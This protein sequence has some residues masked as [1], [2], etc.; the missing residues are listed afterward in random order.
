MQVL[1]RKDIF[2][3]MDSK[4]YAKL[5]SKIAPNSEV[6]YKNILYCVWKNRFIDK[7]QT[8]SSKLGD[9]LFF[10][11][12]WEKKFPKNEIKLEK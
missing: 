11:E 10:K 8:K 7:M 1:E 3:S 2:S 6:S 4:K 9:F 12:K 5:G